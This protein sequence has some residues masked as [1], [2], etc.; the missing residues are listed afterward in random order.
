MVR[1]WPFRGG[2]SGL[3]SVG[4][5]CVSVSVM[6]RFLFVYYTFSTV[7]VAWWPPFGKY[8]PAWLAICS[9]CVLSV[10]GVCLFFVLV[11]FG[12]GFAFWLLRFL[13]I[14]FLLL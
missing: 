11:F 9:H 3:V 8:L 13:F 14:A 5:F 1:C 10:C 4:Y 2:G 12:A 6:F 7:W